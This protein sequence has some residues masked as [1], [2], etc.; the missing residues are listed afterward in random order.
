MSYSS[1]L[2]RVIA[3]YRK[4]T[5]TGDAVESWDNKGEIR[6]TLEDLTRSYN[7]SIELKDLQVSHIVYVLPGHPIKTGD[8]LTIGTGNYIV[9]RIVN[10]MGMNKVIEIYVS[11]T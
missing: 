7:L 11:E 5:L 8:K 2:N 9:K 10:V 3:V 4:K 6:G 1:L